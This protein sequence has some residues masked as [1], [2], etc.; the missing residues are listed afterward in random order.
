MTYSIVARDPGSGA[1][2]GAVQSHHFGVGQLV[3]WAESGVGVVATQS[4]VEVSYGPHGL[5]RMR[6]GMTAGASL[7]SLVADD[8]LSDLRQVAIV[9][10]TGEVAV[11][12]GAACVGHAGHKVQPQVSA[13]ANMM[14]RDTVWGAM[15]DGYLGAAGE[16][17]ANRLHLALEAGEQEGG[18]VRGMQSAAL[19]VVDAESGDR[20][21]DH[22]LVDLRVDDSHQPLVELRR[23]LNISHGADRMDAVLNGDLL[24][25][26]SLDPDSSELA[27]ALRDL[28]A[29]QRLLG[30][31]REPT[32]WSA[33]L[34][35]KA[36]RIDEARDTF[37]R[38]RRQ[39]A[40]GRCLLRGSAPLVFSPPTARSWVTPNAGGGTP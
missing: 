29:A 27:K 12:T 37:E 13:Q 40:A 7:A 33:V 10:K 36:G 23:L 1:L 18:D 5:N 21:W 30:A 15:V 20:P 2:G 28:D 9:D 8:P 4:I 22:R 31:N 3:L 11:H 32:L 38:P 39:I 24:V 25:A 34:L 26:P 16:D 35:A 14:E 6:A 17:L 19:L